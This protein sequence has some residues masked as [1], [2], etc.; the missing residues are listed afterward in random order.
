LAQQILFYLP[1]RQKQKTEWCFVNAYAWKPDSVHSRHCAVAFT[2]R[3][4]V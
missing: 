3:L 4:L 2:H 1:D